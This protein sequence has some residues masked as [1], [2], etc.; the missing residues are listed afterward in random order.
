MFWLVFFKRENNWPIAAELCCSV[1]HCQSGQ[2]LEWDLWHHRCASNPL[3]SQPPLDEDTRS[4]CL[5]WNKVL[6]C[7]SQCTS[8]Y[9][10]CVSCLS[11]PKHKQTCAQKRW[12][13]G[14]LS[15]EFLQCCRA[16]VF[17][18]KDKTDFRYL[19]ETETENVQNGVFN[20]DL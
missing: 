20:T 6:F 18:L 13:S 1:Q 3:P 17:L 10:Y 11:Y 4:S 8:T 15:G 5:N 9:N 16:K 12:V 19:N 7:S 14:Q 2:P